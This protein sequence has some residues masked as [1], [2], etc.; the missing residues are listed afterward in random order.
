MESNKIILDVDILRLHFCGSERWR[1]AVGEK[2]GLIDRN[3]ITVRHFRTGSC[4]TV[5]V[6]R[7]GPGGKT[8]MDRDCK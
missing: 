8:L 5:R 2:G 4:N 7:E 6:V 3:W 1:R